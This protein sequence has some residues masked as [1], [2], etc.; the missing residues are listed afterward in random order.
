MTLEE[1]FNKIIKNDEIHAKW[2]NSL[3]YLEYSGFRK[4]VKS[5]VSDTL[6]DTILSHILEEA[7]HSF[8]FKKLALGIGG[9][10]FNTFKESTLLS[11]KAVKNYFHSLDH[12][13]LKIIENSN[14]K[15]EGAYFLTTWL[16]EERALSMYQRY[17]E[18]LVKNNFNISLSPVLN[19]ESKHL[20]SVLHDLS[21]YFPEL[22]DLKPIFKNF[23]H[24]CFEILWAALIYEINNSKKLEVFL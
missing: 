16:I 23:E 22:Q 15:K 2:L 11:A 7:R 5:Q 20:E 17:Q 21:H 1:F 4:I 13:I 18:V 10:K 9:S 3:S 8:Y 19:D 24:E 6:S 12:G 14:N